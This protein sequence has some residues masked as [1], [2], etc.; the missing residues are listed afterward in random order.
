MLLAVG[1]FATPVVAQDGTGPYFRIGFGTSDTD[2]ESDRGDAGE[3]IRRSY[4]GALL[5]EGAIGLRLG[6]ALRLEGEIVHMQRDTDTAVGD[7]RGLDD[8]AEGELEVLAGLANVYWDFR[9][10]KLVQPYLGAGAGVA[11]VEEDFSFQIAAPRTAD[12]SETLLAYGV[13]AGARIGLSQRVDYGIGYR[14]FAT[15]DRDDLTRRTSTYPLG[16]LE[17]HLLEVDLGLRF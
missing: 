6:D 11:R 13:K 7:P 2:R 8:R 4:G 14:F 16:G 10:D 3:V 15:E 5:L 17:I 1:L 9:R 12:L